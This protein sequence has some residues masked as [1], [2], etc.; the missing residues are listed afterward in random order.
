MP[1]ALLIMISILKK[2]ILGYI[3]LCFQEHM[4]LTHKLYKSFTLFQASYLN[5]QCLIYKII[6]TWFVLVIVH[7]FGS[8][9]GFVP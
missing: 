3:T 2:T 6:L 1:L 4:C 8:L 7:L 9:F 5:S